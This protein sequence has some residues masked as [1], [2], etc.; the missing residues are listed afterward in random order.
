MVAKGADWIALNAPSA[1]HS[2]RTSVRILGA[3]GVE[4][5][6]DDRDKREV[7]IRLV[8]LLELPEDGV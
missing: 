8:E 5:A 4:F 6:I 1:L 7:A 2:K 3:A